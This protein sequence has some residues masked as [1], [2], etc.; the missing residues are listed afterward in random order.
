LHSYAYIEVIFPEIVDAGKCYTTYWVVVRGNEM[1]LVILGLLSSISTS[2][3]DLNCDSFK[4]L[5]N[6][7]CGL[8]ISSKQFA[9]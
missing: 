8:N 9:C 7:T 6:S 4:M 5:I 1:V 3:S 2:S